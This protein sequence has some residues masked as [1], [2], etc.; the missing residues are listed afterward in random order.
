MAIR[1]DSGTIRSPIKTPEGY[2][3]AVGS[4]AKQGILEY[5]TPD[6]G[7]R[8][9]F[10]PGEENEKALK[11]WASQVV[12]NEHP[13][14]LV[15][16]ENAKQY[17]VGITDS[18]VFLEDDY[19]RGVVII[20]DAEAV[21][22][23]E[24]GDT[25]EIS[26][27]YK[28]R[29]INEP[30]TWR[31]QHYDAVQID[32]EPNHVALTKKGRAG[33][34]VA[35]HLDSD[36]KDVA[37]QTTNKHKSMA[38]LTIKGATYEVDPLIASV[39]SGHI[40]DLEKQAIKADSLSEKETE[41]D[42]Q[43]A[44]LQQQIEEL[45][46]ERDRYQGHADAYEVVTTN[47][48]PIL[49]KYGYAWNADSEEFVLDSKKK[50][51]M[52][53]EDEEED[54]EE[55]Y[56]D[57][58]EMMPK[59]K[60]KKMD[61]KKMDMKKYDS[62]DEDDE[63]EEG[64]EDDDEEYED[65]EEMTARKDSV[66]VILEAWKKAEDLGLNFKFDSA[67]DRDDI[68]HAITSKLMPDV[69]LSNASSAYLEGVIDRLLIESQSEDEGDDFGRTDSADTDIY[70]TNLQQMV[71]LT[72]GGENPAQKQVGRSQELSNAWQQPL[73]LSKNS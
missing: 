73:S 67:L 42:K 6:G 4:F 13:D 33:S 56:E 38:S 26:T 53:E 47:A 3:K 59:S 41:L 9:E 54:E 2:F 19:V 22:S 32:I 7:I 51:M 10:R 71:G 18:T 49:E 1:F 34:D 25:T 64:D 39:V 8:R 15:N 62:S 57:E 61:M 55:E 24:R 43:I 68:Y 63:E 21:R 66:P 37:Y 58:E 45:T 40:S 50:K 23:I 17:Q 48:L 20:T 65:E 69:D 35:L 44:S 29:V 70:S 16:A 11:K 14:R 72:R 27:G 5:R 46:E 30:G 60:K 36:D 31:G 12:T 52:V 28:C